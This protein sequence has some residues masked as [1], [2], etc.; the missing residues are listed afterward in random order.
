[1]ENKLLTITTEFGKSRGTQYSLIT[2]LEQ[3]K[4]SLDKGEFVS[5][6][7]IDLPKAFGTINHDLL[8]AK[9]HAYSFSDKTLNL[10]GSYLKD[11][12][13][14]VQRNNSFNLE[15]KCRP[16]FCKALLVAHY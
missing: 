14:T 4:N 11:Q 10:V 2:M 12:K 1:M 3:F 6:I 8:L 7:F 9:L 15:K 5:L 13:Q 16:V